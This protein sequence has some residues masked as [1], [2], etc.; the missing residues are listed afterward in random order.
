MQNKDNCDSNESVDDWKET[1]VAF[2]T[3]NSPNINPKDR[4]KDLVNEW[5]ENTKELGSFVN[6]N[7]S[8]NNDKGL[9]LI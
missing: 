5:K 3:D 1:L 7:K 8:L 6:I 4:Y 9:A 2:I